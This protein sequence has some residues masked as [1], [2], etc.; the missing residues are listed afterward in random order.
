MARKILASRMGSAIWSCVMIT[1]SSRLKAISRLF[2]PHRY[3]TVHLFLGHPAFFCLP[4]H[5]HTPTLEY[6]HHSLL[7]NV[8]ATYIYNLV[9]FHVNSVYLVLLFIRFMAI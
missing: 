3:T 1:I 6:V 9:H 7:I 4:E 2:H 5:I 8:M